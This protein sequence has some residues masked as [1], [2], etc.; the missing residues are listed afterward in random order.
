MG[1]T[2]ISKKECNPK[3]VEDKRERQLSSA[4][5]DICTGIRLATTT[6]VNMV[7]HIRL[8]RPWSPLLRPSV[9]Q[10]TAPPPRRYAKAG[11]HGM[12]QR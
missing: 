2:L 1:C 9:N 5:S 8:S 7:H 3:D 6:G 4:T 11:S 10:P 12:R